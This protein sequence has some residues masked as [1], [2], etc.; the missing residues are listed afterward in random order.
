[1]REVVDHG[2]L[3]RVAPPVRGPELERLDE[4]VGDAR[5][6]RAANGVAVA[7]EQHELLAARRRPAVAGYLR[8]HLV[9][10]KVGDEVLERRGEPLRR[11]GLLLRAQLEQLEAV[12][13]EVE[14]A[15]TRVRP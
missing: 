14:L 9:E 10:P 8:Q 2:R 12:A 6:A 1:R 15:A 3:D 4:V 13:A 5:G 11:V 7:R